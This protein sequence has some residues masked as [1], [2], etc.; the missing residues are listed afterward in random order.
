MHAT[1]SPVSVYPGIATRLDLRTGP[2][3][4]PPSFYYALQSVALVPQEKPAPTFENPNPE[5]PADLEVCTTLKDGNVSMT[6][7]QWDNWPATDPKTIAEKVQ[8]SIEDD[9]YCLNAAAANL[10]LEILEQ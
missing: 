8:S 6:E 5:K 2:L 3:G 4:P 9:A 1:I 10:G 7:K